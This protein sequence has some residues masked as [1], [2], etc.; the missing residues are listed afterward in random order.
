MEFVVKGIRL[1]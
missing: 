1:G